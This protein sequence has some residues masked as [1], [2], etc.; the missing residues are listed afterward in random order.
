MKLHRRSKLIIA[1]L[2]FLLL[3]SSLSFKCDGGNNNTGPAD[4]NKAFRNAAKASDDV[5]KGISE[6][7]DLKRTLAAQKKI[8]SD[9]ETKLTDL[10]LKANTADKV[11]V[12]QIKVMRAAG[13]APDGA[14]KAN[15]AS[16]FSQVTSALN[17]LSNA[18]LLP[19]GNGDAKGQLQ[20]VLAAATAAAQII[21][22]F[23][24]P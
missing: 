9:E 12:D 4:P 17:D 21:E 7:I 15:L 8:S 10:L 14:A 1:G 18:G 23:L 5:A 2:A 11:F 19:L 13:T 24:K 16:L 20:K 22:A 3:F 6:M